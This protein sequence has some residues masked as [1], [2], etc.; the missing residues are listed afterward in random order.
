M[1]LKF[2]RILAV[3]LVANE[4]QSMPLALAAPRKVKDSICN[5]VSTRK[6]ISPQRGLSCQAGKVGKDFFH[7]A[8]I[9]DLAVLHPAG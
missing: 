3:V 4:L 5:W 2:P 6:R 1:F 7:P 9:C 8:E